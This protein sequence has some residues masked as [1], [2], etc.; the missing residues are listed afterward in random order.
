[1]IAFLSLSLSFYCT[2]L[3]TH[4][5]GT[6]LCTHVCTQQAGVVTGEI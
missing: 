3:C 5:C 6:A 1:V 2:V 4:L